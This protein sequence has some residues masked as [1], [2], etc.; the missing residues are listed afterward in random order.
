[1]A[2]SHVLGSYMV[3]NGY[4]IGQCRSGTFSALQKVLMDGVPQCRAPLIAG[5]RIHNG[6]EK[7]LSVI[8]DNTLVECI[9]KESWS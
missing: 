4:H 2:T 6:T 3:A 5:L 7:Y 9:V 1:M 8:C